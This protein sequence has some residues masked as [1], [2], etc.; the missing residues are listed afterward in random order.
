VVAGVRAGTTGGSADLV[1][2]DLAV[3]LYVS[4]GDLKPIS[5]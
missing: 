3:D 4:I 2:V 5:H 1:T